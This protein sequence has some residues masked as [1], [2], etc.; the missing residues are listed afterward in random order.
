MAGRR[1][2][3]AAGDGG[4]DMGIVAASNFQ[5]ALL[6]D[7]ELP[8]SIWETAALTSS[9]RRNPKAEESY[10]ELLRLMLSLFYSRDGI[11]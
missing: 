8:K 4:E 2:S 10:S 9:R 3:R 7:S 5:T 1:A 6:P 11:A